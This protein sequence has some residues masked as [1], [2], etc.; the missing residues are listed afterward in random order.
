MV[1]AT[2]H[3]LLGKVRETCCLPSISAKAENGRIQELSWISFSCH[4][5]HNRLTCATLA[6]K[7]IRAVA[8]PRP[9]AWRPKLYQ[10]KGC[11]RFWKSMLE[12]MTLLRNFSFSIFLDQYWSFDIIWFCYRT[13]FS[14][15]CFFMVVR[16]HQWSVFTSTCLTLPMSH[17]G[18]FVSPRAVAAA[19]KELPVSAPSGGLRKDPRL[20]QTREVRLGDSGWHDNYEDIGPNY[21]ITCSFISLL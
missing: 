6:S 14:F 10:L 17:P 20:R 18:E 7:A 12:A 4:T 1:A 13:K 9:M 8:R 21:L 3:E 15:F 11:H 2:Q 19:L 5:Y 16:Y